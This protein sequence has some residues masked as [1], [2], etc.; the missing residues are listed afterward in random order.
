M[1]GTADC[2]PVALL[3]P[4]AVAIVHAGRRGILAGIVTR[5]LQRMAAAGVRAGSLTA[6]VGPAIG[7]CCYEI[8]PDTRAG[9]VDRYPRSAATSRRG[10]P[11]VDLRTAVETDLRAGDVDT[12]VH[13]GECTAHQPD[14]YFSAR[15]DP[16]T[17]YQAGVVVLCDSAG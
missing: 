11:A 14:R 16:V 1:I 13:A 6:V 8:D 9:F 10:N 12:I 15:R 7:G 4:G 3:G 17:G 2:V 5:A